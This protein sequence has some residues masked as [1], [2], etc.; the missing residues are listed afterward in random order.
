MPHRVTVGIALAVAASASAAQV[1]RCP[2]PGGRVVIQQVPC[3]DGKKLDVKPATGYDNPSNAAEGRE[4]AAR[5]GSAQDIL[6]AISEGRPAIGMSEEQLRSAMGNPT[7]INRSNYEGNVSDQWVYGKGG[8]P[9]YVYLREGRVSGIQST[10]VTQAGAGSGKR[11]PT[12]IEIRNMETSASS[13]TISDAE[14]GALRRQV[15]DAKRCR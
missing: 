12:A 13:V 2:D 8:R 7:R 6:L 4:R 3:M 15:A 9:T 5:Q 1:Y 14:R 11:C 10:E